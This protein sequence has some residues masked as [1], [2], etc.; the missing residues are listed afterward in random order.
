MS[1]FKLVNVKGDLFATTFT[2]TMQAFIKL[3]SSLILTR[4]LRPEAYGVI[5]I[6]MSIVF[7][8]EMV[9]DL[10]VTVF[11]VRDKNGETP[12]YLNTAWTLRL[13]RNL[14][15]AAFT[16]S[17][18]SIIASLY[19][20]P[21][22][23]TPLRVFSLWFV[24][25]GFESM[26]FP[27][28]IRRKRS[29]ILMYSEL[30]ATLLSTL[31]AV[32][33]SFYSRDY[34]GMLYATLLSRLLLTVLSRR[35]YP[36]FRP[37]LQ[38]DR[39]AAREMFRLTRY[40]LP[41]SFLSMVLS[42]FDR[43]VFLRLFNLHLLGLYG[44]A[45]GIASPIEALVSNI[46]RMVLYP[47]C[48]HNFRSDPETF[49]LKYYTENVKLFA[50]MLTLPAV[51]WGAA[52]LIISV[53]YPSRYAQ[54]M[55]VLQAF[56]VRACLLSLASPAE[57][58]LIATGASQIILIGNLYRAG[59]MFAASLAGYYFFGFTGFMYGAALSGLPPLIY[60]LW[61]QHKKRMLIAKYEFYKVAFVLG[62][63]VA[64]HLVSNLL[65]ATWPDFKLRS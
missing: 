64:A 56:M 29:R 8:V 5:T 49:A 42:Q 25:G 24:I 34:W 30:T 12:S 44:L 26:S 14:L 47:R 31:F 19:G 18:A 53:L 2:F 43:V 23:E 52:H 4:I 7:V 50:S 54:S 58:M 48:A 10:G 16:F 57:E 62:V 9:A 65:L 6:V 46:S 28:A 17:S 22:L 15:S 20:I 27:I 63:A 33:Y 41:S 51:G 3:C 55:P 1:N 61:M 40:V 60:Y 36:E 13:G 45:G 38:I 37:K 32:I 11:I 21:D 59:W 39:T 35:F